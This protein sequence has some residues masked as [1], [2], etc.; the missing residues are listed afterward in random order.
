MKKLI[1]IIFIM[2]SLT[3]L[4][5]KAKGYNIEKE[6]VIQMVYDT[7]KLVFNENHDEWNDI[8]LGTLAAETDI[9][10]YRAGSKHG[11]AQI[12]PVAFKFIKQQVIKDKETYAKLKSN[13]LDFKKI[14]FNELT[15]NHKASVVAMTLYYKYVTETKKVNIHGK[16]KAEVW[17]KYYNTYAGA[18][19]KQHF[20]KAYNRNKDIIKDTLLVCKANDINL[21][22]DV[23]VEEMRNEF[24]ASSKPLLDDLK[25][26]VSSVKTT[27]EHSDSFTTFTYTVKLHK[28][29]I[30]GFAYKVLNKSITRLI[31]LRA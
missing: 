31:T 13:G 5:A 11:I 28:S 6:E 20:N 27:V 3:S 16:D 23:K 24:L 22:K 18:G 4:S 2:F 26:N 30:I 1:G 7:T 8:I 19:T 10:A 25:T 14:T 17:K 21:V 9:G 15:H 12:T 29:E